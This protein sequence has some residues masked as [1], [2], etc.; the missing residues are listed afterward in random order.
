MRVLVTGASGFL[1][2]HVV[3]VLGSRGHPVRALDIANGP[4]P[5]GA[6]ESV[7]ADVGDPDACRDACQGVEVVLHLAARSSDFGSAERFA[8][9]LRGLRNLLDAAVVAG[10]RR[11]VFVSSVAV[12]ELPQYGATED[13][14][15]DGQTLPFGEAKRAG[16]QLCEEY[17][18]TGRLETVIVRPGVFPFGP[19]DFRATYRL[20]DRLAHR[21]VALC[22]RG[23]GVT[24]TAYAENV[25]H[26]LALA[27]LVPAAAGRT[28]LIDDGEP[29][30][31]Y[32]LCDRFTDALEVKPPRYGP[33][34]WVALALATLGETWARATG[35][36]EVP[37]TRYRARLFATDFYFR[38]T[39]AHRE[40][41]YAPPV[42]M[43]EA[44]AR[45]VQWY[46]SAA[47]SRNGNP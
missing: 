37:L 12:H 43:A 35:R 4:P 38:S 34:L 41:G 13:T 42:P 21:K 11:L 10:V 32:D 15:R 40:L 27:A 16:E 20:L 29:L 8:P 1:G 3:R 5:I 22:A 9:N 26:G 24:T 23:R 44:I 45:T 46:R 7:Q 39:R 33:P 19:G 2:Q 18:A 30:A 28:Y 6:A 36:Q 17:Q 25:A 31:W 47:E 14:P